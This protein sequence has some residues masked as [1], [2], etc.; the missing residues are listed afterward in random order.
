MSLYV[1][2]DLDGTLLRSDA[3][4]SPYSKQI[5]TEAIEAGATIGYATARSYISSQRAA[6]AIPWKHPLVL[7][8]GAMVVDPLT[9]QVLGGA[10][11]DRGIT[12]EIIE[13]G[14][15]FGLT[16]LLFALDSEDQ[17]KVYH[18]RLSRAGDAAFYESRPNDPRFTEQ[19]SLNCPADSRTLI[20]TYIGLLN[21]LEPLEARIRRQ[22]GSQVCI[23]F[24]KDSYIRDHYFL[25]FSHP[26]ANKKEGARKWASFVGCG[27][28]Q[29]TVF[30]DNLNDVG[31]FEAAGIRVAVANAH[32]S[33]I[34]MASHHA[35]S[36]NEDG[37][38]RFIRNMLAGELKSTS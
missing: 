36:N 19:K 32:P 14:K 4:L 23:H 34:S 29:L 31:L 18:E 24:M 30:G 8:N 38:A 22:F 11:L 1:L 6:G 27:L 20:I 28:E 13:V 26:D 10:W 17:E 12:N 5:M 3:T 35:D 37:V 2:T 25:E 9:E 7:Y 15:A 33:L 21:E 16:P